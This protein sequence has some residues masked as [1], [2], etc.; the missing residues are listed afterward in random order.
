MIFSR[1]D[2]PSVASMMK[3]DRILMN[4]DWFVDIAP[5]LRVRRRSD[6]KMSDFYRN[7][8]ASLVEVPVE[9]V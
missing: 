1:G 7:P 4:F 6:K 9:G 2:R 3:N 8:V 5:K